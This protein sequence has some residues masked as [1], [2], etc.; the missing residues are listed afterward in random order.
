[1][2]KSIDNDVMLVDKTFGFDTVVQE[3]VTRPL[4]AAKVEAASARKGVGLVKV[5]VP[6]CDK[7]GWVGLGLSLCIANQG[8]TCT[9]GGGKVVWC[10]HG[11]GTG[12]GRDMV[13]VFM[14]L[15]LLYAGR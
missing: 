5:R 12:Q 11:G 2:P 1:M 4:M 3:V 7:T 15:G 13:F 9:Q 8:Q 14:A 10:C 6:D